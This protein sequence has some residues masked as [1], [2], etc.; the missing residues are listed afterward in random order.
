MRLSELIDNKFKLPSVEKMLSQTFKDVEA[1][2]R[3]T[4]FYKRQCITT[5]VSTIMMTYVKIWVGI[6][7]ERRTG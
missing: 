7:G 6:C 5:L 2:Q 1:M 3:T 4:R